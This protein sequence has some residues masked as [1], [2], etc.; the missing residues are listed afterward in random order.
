MSELS[1][2]ELSTTQNKETRKNKKELRTKAKGKT[3]SFK[4]GRWSPEEHSRYNQACVMH[5]RNWKKVSESVGTRSA[6]QVK[7]H[8]KRLEDAKKKD[9]YKEKQ[10][11]IYDFLANREDSIWGASQ[12]AGSVGEATRIIVTRELSDRLSSVF[13][14]AL[15]PDFVLTKDFVKLVGISEMK[16]LI[17]C[18]SYPPQPLIFERPEL[19]PTC[20]N[21]VE[22]DEREAGVGL[23]DFDIGNAAD[24]MSPQLST[25]ISPYL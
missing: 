15:N 6:L 25:P 10:R 22:G 1:D 16:G 13:G 17:N 23:L 18:P 19:N 8:N 20:S 24:Y 9:K 5:P 12:S 3:H 2:P 11:A 4:R 21:A 7:T 14:A